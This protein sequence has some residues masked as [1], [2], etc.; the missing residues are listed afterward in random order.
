MGLAWTQDVLRHSFGT[1]Y[2][3][4]THDI[5][6]VSHDM[7]NGIG[8]CKSHYVREVRKDWTTKFW[9]LRPKTSPQK[10]LVEKQDIHQGI[11]VAVAES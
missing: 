8:V 2:Y 5:N 6:Q 11:C 7:G 9:G 3:N 4:L 1:Y 10:A